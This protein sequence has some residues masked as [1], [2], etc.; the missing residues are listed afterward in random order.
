MWSI[1]PHFLILSNEDADPTIIIK[2]IDMNEVLPVC[3]GCT[4]LRLGIEKEKS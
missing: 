4:V 3:I 2:I 1:I